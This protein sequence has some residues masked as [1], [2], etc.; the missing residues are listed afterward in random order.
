MS[1][2][3]RSPM[4]AIAIAVAIVIVA[5]LPAGACYRPRLVDCVVKCD[6]TQSC[7]DGMSC[8]AG[9]CTRGATCAVA[10]SSGARHSCAIRG[11]AVTCWGNNTYGQLGGPGSGTATGARSSPPDLGAAATALAAGGRH[12]CA[13]LAGDGAKV[14][15][16]GDNAHAQL[17][18]GAAPPATSPNV[19]SFG[20]GHL[21][22]S[23]SAGLN[24]TCVVDNDDGG[25]TKSG[26]VRCWGDAHLG[27]LGLPEMPAGAAISPS[28]LSAVD[29][30]AAR[31]V[32]VSAG[33]YH[34]C[35]L[36]E[37][38]AVDCWGWNDNLQLGM[39]DGGQLPG[40]VVAVELAGPAHAI[41]AGGFQTCA[42]LDGGAVSCWGQDDAG[43]IG[44]RTIKG[45]PGVAPASIDLGHGRTARSISV[46]ASHACALLDDFSV[47]CW[48]LNLDGE[49]GL[50]DTRNRG[51][52]GLLGD[53]LPRVGLGQ[54]PV[55]MI[56]AGANHTCAIQ[57]PEVKCWGSNDSGRLGIDDGENRGDDPSHPI[58]A[59]PF[60]M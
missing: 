3:R 20:T 12:T 51:D 19:V 45:L 53:A 17:G 49:L 26:P 41:A 23:I 43:Q 24:H 46:G 5:A 1:P 37:D 11:P 44:V 35:A 59:V 7:P 33:A 60:G 10:V 39:D 9:L 55:S 28:G 25:V 2:R 52:D 4:A 18:V 34:T 6:R 42:I 47:K 40:T 13:A 21:I 58:I 36:L 16:W 56:S 14:A 29:L 31:A 8:A 48:G 22:V 30:G 54:D 57:G 15:C 32:A 50:G 38:G 27:Q